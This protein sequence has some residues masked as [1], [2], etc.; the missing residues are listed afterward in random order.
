MKR[1]AE[2]GWVNIIGGCCGTTPEHIKAMKSAL[3]SLKPRDHHE[4][5]GHGISGLEALQYDESMRP[6][7]VGERTNVIGSRKFK[8]LVA[9]GKFEEAESGKSAS[10][11][12][13]SYY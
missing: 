8:R 2:E 4:R 9:E 1:F 5:E 11:E 13:C 6:L 3:A 12:K 7:F 10:E